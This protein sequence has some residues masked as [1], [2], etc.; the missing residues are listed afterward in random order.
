MSMKTKHTILITGLS[1]HLILA[2][3]AL[4]IVGALLGS[5]VLQGSTRSALAKSIN[6][7]TQNI[8]ADDPTGTITIGK[9]TLPAG[10]TGFGFTSDIPGNAAFTLG[11]GD[12]LTFSDV[13]VGTYTVSE[14]DPGP[15][16]ALISVSCSFSG[17]SDVILDLG[18][19]TATITLADDG[20]VDCDYTNEDQAPQVG[21]DITSQDVQYSDLIQP[22]TVTASDNASDVLSLTTQWNKDGGSFTAGLPDFLNE[23]DNGCSTTGDAQLC[24]WTISG[25]TGVA[26]GQYTIR[27]TVTDNSGHSAD[28]DILINVSPEDATVTFDSNN[29]V[30]IPVTDPGSNSSEAFA[31]LLHIQEAAESGTGAAPGDINLAQVTLTIT[32][33]TSGAPRT[34]TC[35]PIGA[36][37]PNDYSAFLTVEC[38]FSGIPVDVY[39]VTATVVGGYYTGTG[40]DV[41]VVYDT[42]LGFTTG[43]GWFYWPG[44]EDLTNGYPGDKTNFGYTMKYK[45]KGLKPKGNLLLIRHMPDGTIH[46]IKSNALD[47]LTLGEAT[48]PGT[49]ETYGWASFSGKTTYLAPGMLEPEGNYT[50]TVYVEDRGEPGAG[51]DRF[52][53]EVLNKDDQVIMDLSMPPDAPDNTVT[54]SGGNIAVPHV[55]GSKK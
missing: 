3:L 13:P 35:S 11:D 41:F 5:G 1:N 17:G 32:S 43:G 34:I 4:I 47:W 45:N 7:I 52:W 23:I 22:V 33:L 42:S 38:P 6:P 51:I 8:Q 50:F 12:S 25:A 48:D 46:R 29:P 27:V 40:E 16:Y 15:L 54:I 20:T 53:I 37:P 18:A 21:V 28:V 30:A 19:R 39:Q 36:V 44:S 10:G 26:T 2:V 24:T 49:G 9:T 55:Q 14:D 31:L